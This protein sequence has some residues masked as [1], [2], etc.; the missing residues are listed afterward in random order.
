MAFAAPDDLGEADGM[1]SKMPWDQIFSVLKVLILAGVI[2]FGARM[3]RDRRRGDALSGATGT[4]MA[5]TGPDGVPA[6]PGAVTGEGQTLEEMEAI[7]SAQSE[8]AM[9]DQE[10]AL[11]QVDGRIKLSALKRIGDAV[12]ASPGESASVVRQWMNT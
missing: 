10:I 8:L 2:L 1:L 6:L 7:R 4:A 9:L 5:L 11:A 12:K 3:L